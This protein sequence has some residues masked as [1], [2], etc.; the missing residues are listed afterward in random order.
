MKYDK[1]GYEKITWSEVIDDI[2][3]KLKQPIERQWNRIGWALVIIAILFYG[4]LVIKF[5]ML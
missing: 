3:D 5:C 4:W 1:R 2:L